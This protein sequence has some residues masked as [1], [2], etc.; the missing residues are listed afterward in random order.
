MQDQIGEAIT[1]VREAGCVSELEALMTKVWDDN[2]P[3]TCNCNGVCDSYCPCMNID[4]E[5]D[6]CGG[7]RG[8]LAPSEYGK[9]GVAGTCQCS[10]N[11]ECD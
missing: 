8:C 4:C 6:D 2:V 10:G 1:N 3:E 7:V 5:D 9:K 11:G